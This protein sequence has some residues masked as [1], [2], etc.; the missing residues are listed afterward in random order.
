MIFFYSGSIVSDFVT[1]FG[2]NFVPCRAVVSP[3]RCSFTIINCQP[4]PG[5]G[6]VSIF[7]SRSGKPMFIAEFI[8]MIL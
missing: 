6:F 7:N 2:N 4:L 8:L 3:F 1:V 5:V